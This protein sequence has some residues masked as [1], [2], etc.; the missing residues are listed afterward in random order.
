MTLATCAGHFHQFSVF[1]SAVWFFIK[2]RSGLRKNIFKIIF[3]PSLGPYG[4]SRPYLVNLYLTDFGTCSANQC[5]QNQIEAIFTNFLCWV[6]LFGFL[7]K[8]AVDFESRIS[9]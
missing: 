8:L 7:L 5:I 1:D 2:T 4:I 9:K 3:A 6:V